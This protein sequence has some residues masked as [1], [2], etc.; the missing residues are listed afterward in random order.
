MGQHLATLVLLTMPLGGCSL[1]YD[2]SDLPAAADAAVPLPDIMPCDMTVTGL[3]PATLFE[4]MGVG[5]SRPALIVVGGTNLAS[6]NTTISITAAA[7]SARVPL[8][9]VDNAKIEVGIYGEQLSVPITLPVDLTLTANET[10]ALDVKIEQDC[11]GG[12]V[13]GRVQGALALKGLDELTSAAAP[14]TGGLH[15]YSQ[16]NVET[17]TLGPATNQTSPIV[18]R[19]MSSVKISSAISLDAAGRTGG[20]AGGNGG[21]GGSGLGGVGTPGTG[22]LPGQSSGAAGGFDSTDPG[23]NTL[24]NPNRS[25]GGAGGSGTVAVGQGGNGGGGGGSIE[26]SAGGD[27]RMG[28]ITA[29]GAAGQPGSAGG[30]AGGGGSGGVILLRAGG[31]LTAGNIDVG[32]AGTGARGRARYDAGGTASVPEG[33]LGT[34]HL[35]GP[36]LAGLP[37]AVR[38]ATP[39]IAVVGKP[40]TAFKYFFIKQ[41]GGVSQLSSAL[42]GAD[43]T[44][45][46]T[47]AE[48]LAPG[49]NQL[50]LVPDPGAAT[51]ETR[52][53]FYLAYLR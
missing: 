35:R 2:P 7:G 45:R 10:I 32:S 20:P 43:G 38:S 15:E 1:L 8:I 37:V 47:L 36:M 48:P 12:R 28:A 16:I 41:G 29:R 31:T 34:D 21:A 53:C 23:L 33:E 5:G 13:A 4:G 26:I 11:A 51:S 24:G 50:C 19:S 40:L 14:L 52:N 3:A 30:A 18:L 39:E 6:Q 17:G 44:A 9:V 25:S 49:A 22:P 46:V 27:L 42:F